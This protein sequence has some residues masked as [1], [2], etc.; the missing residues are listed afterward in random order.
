[1]VIDSHVVSLTVD[2]QRLVLTH[3]PNDIT[4]GSQALVENLSC[5]P[6]HAVLGQHAANMHVPY[7]V[8]Q[9]CFRHSGFSYCCMYFCSSGP[10]GAC[11]AWSSVASM[12][13]SA[14][15]GAV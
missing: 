14:T 1:M 15:Q 7:A 11:F 8:M 2:F 4:E 6:T 3:S 5:L 12:S 10:M 13:R 9:A